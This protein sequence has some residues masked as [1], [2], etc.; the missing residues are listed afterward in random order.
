MSTKTKI[1]ICPF[2]QTPF[3][4]CYCF[5]FTS[6]DIDRAIYFCGKNFKKCRIYM[7]K[8]FGQR[9]NNN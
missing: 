8:S 7:E 9:M 6:K 5:N 1:E 4:N 2:V 3:N